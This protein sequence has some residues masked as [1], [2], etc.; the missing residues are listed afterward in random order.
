MKKLYSAL[1]TLLIVTVAVSGIAVAIAKESDFEEELERRLSFFDNYDVLRYNYFEPSRVKQVV[2]EH[3]AESDIKWGDH[4][5]QRGSVFG[6]AL[7]KR[8]GP[9]DI[10]DFRWRIRLVDEEEYDDNSTSGVTVFDYDKSGVAD[11]DARWINLR[12]GRA[13]TFGGRSFAHETRLTGSV[14]LGS[15]QLGQTNF[16]DLGVNVGNRQSYKE[17]GYK[18]STAVR[19]AGTFLVS[20]YYAERHLYA[21]IKTGFTMVGVQSVLWLKKIGNKSVKLMVNLEREETEFDDL[22]QESEYIKVGVRINQVR[23]SKKKDETI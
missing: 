13:I 5:L 4:L 10:S 23:E 12:L 3:S 2:W 6:V 17:A 14:G 7:G 11:L 15:I 18:L 1:L 16:P 9:G 19:F 20:A 8:F 22:S 21:D